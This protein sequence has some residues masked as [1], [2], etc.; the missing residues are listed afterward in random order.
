MQ[1]FSADIANRVIDAR[2]YVTVVAGLQNGFLISDAAMGFAAEHIEDLS[3]GLMRVGRK[4]SP[5]Q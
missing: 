5:R 2:R 3:G 4:F 1:V